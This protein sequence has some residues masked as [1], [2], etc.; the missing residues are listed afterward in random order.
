MYKYV[1]YSKHGYPK[2]RMDVPI[3]F[4]LNQCL[5]FDRFSSGLMEGIICFVEIL[6]HGYRKGGSNAAFPIKT[7][8]QNIDDFFYCY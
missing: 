7:I 4:L 8:I 6:T 1:P 5:S 2:Q 3:L